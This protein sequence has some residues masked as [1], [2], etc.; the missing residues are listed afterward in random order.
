MRRGSTTD[1]RQAQDAID[2]LTAIP[3]EPGIVVHEIWL[4]RMRALLAQA[5]GD[6]TAYREYRDRYRKMASELG[7]E[8]HMKWAAAM[9]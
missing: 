4:R 5:Q 3:T 7:F 1:L 8:G 9:D 2:A 6:D